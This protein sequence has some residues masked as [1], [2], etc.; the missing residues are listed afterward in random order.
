MKRL[1]RMKSKVLK[2]SVHTGRLDCGL[3]TFVWP[4]PGFTRKFGLVSVKYGS[5]DN[6]F[7]PPGESEALRVPEGIA[8]FLEHKLFEDKKGD[9]TERFSALGASCNA[10]TSFTSTTYYFSCTDNFE[11]SLRLLLGMVRRPDFSPAGIEKE[12][13]IIGQEIMMERDN[14]DWRVFLNMLCGMYARHPVRVDIA[15]TAD[16]IARID[17]DLLVKCHR[18]FYHPRNM[19]LVAAGDMNPDVVVKTAERVFGRT[20]AG[21][22]D[23][24]RIIPE[25]PDRPAREKVGDRMAVNRPKLLLGFKEEDTGAT[26]SDLFRKDILTALVLDTLFGRTSDLYND[27]YSRGLVDGPFSAS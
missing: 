22:G 20:R 4:M 11:K 19:V 2:S 1:K 18:T 3:Q 21:N 7:V 10:M 9:V 6:E 8:H 23:I 15:G 25:E 5:V 13:G 17:R 27:L 16:S 26:S 24:R 14:P 12:K